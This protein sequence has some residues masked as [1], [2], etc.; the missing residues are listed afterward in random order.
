MNGADV[1]LRDST[2][3]VVA[4]TATNYLGAFL[5]PAPVPG[6]YS[7]RA[8]AI[9][10]RSRDS[11]S[12]EVKE[13]EV[14]TV[15]LSLPPGPVELDTLDVE[16][17][18]QRIIPHL[19][20]EGFYKRLE[21]GFGYFITPEEI[22]ANNPRY[23]HDLFRGIPGVRATWDGRLDLGPRCREFPRR[24]FV[25]GI[26]IDD[27]MITLGQRLLIGDIEA[28]EVYLGPASVPL[29]YGGTEGHCVVL[30]WTKG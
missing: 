9:G 25:D 19:E 18:R 11:D 28:V 24:V 2:G 17:E 20:R 22:E 7:L 16:A 1:A 26:Q 29:Q 15:D 12:F 8:E 27:T 14:T 13:G 30:F 23:F 10:Y 4:R 6:V 3:T 5:I 21:D